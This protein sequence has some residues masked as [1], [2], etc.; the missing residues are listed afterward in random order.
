MKNNRKLLSLAAAILFVAAV[1]ASAVSAVDPISGIWGMKPPENGTYYLT[2]TAYGSEG[3]KD[4]RGP[5]KAFDNVTQTHFESRNED[6]GEWC[7]LEF[8]S[9]YV[10]TEIR[11]FPRLGNPGKLVGGRFEVSKDGKDWTIVHEITET[12]GIDF[13]AVQILHPYPVSHVRYINDSIRANIS[14]IEI[15]GCTEAEAKNSDAITAIVDA[16]RPNIHTLSALDSAATPVM[17]LILA[18][19]VAGGT[20]FILKKTKPGNGERQI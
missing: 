14:E 18:A 20:V 15:Y 19:I 5:E 7:A 12:P 13:T 6:P 17:V 3:S 2:G 16:M 1:C 10:V 8:A 11:F 4:D 9:P